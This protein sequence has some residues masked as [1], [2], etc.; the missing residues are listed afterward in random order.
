MSWFILIRILVFVAAIVIGLSAYIQLWERG[1]AEIRSGRRVPPRTSAGQ[2][3]L[4]AKAPGGILWGVLL[5]LSQAALL[6]VAFQALGGL[7]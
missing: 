3:F 5:L 6:V 1:E 4:G 2:L 7:R